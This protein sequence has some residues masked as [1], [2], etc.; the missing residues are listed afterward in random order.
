MARYQ[1]KHFSG[2]HDITLDVFPSI[3]CIPR[4]F[5]SILALVASHSPGR[6]PITFWP[7]QTDTELEQSFWTALHNPYCVNILPL[8][9]SIRQYHRGKDV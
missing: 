2:P 3:L 7:A 5:R 6:G 8:G 4:H 1:A 9:R